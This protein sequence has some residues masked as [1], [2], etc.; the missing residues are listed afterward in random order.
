MTS[1]KVL[2]VELCSGAGGMA[3]GFRRA[4]VTFDVVIDKD[5]NAVA[6]YER[7]LGHCPVQMDVR[8]VLRLA[9]LGAFRPQVRLLVADPPCTPWSLAGKRKG[10]EDER[11]VLAETCELVEILRPQ[12]FLIANIPGLEAAPNVAAVQKTIGRLAEHG[13]CVRDAA[14]LDAAD[15][16]VP[17]HRVRPFWFGHLSGPCLR[18]PAPT[19]RDPG[20]P[21]LAFDGRKP[22]VTC[23]QALGHLPA[24]DLGRVVRGRNGG[25]PR[26]G[27]WNRPSCLDSQ[28]RTIRTARMYGTDQPQSAREIDADA[29]APAVQGALE[30]RNARATWPASVRD[31]FDRPATTV[32]AGTP[33]LW[34]P[35]SGAPNRR[36]WPWDAPSTTVLRDERLENPG[37]HAPSEKTTGGYVRLSE[38]AAAI[39]QGF[40]ENW[41]FAGST[42]S[43]RW[44]QIG[45]ATPP[46]LAE[47]V[48]RQI[49]AWLAARE[50]EAEF[51]A[52]P[53]AD[54]PAL[55]AELSAVRA[56]LLAVVRAME[57]WG[58]WE[59]GVP[60]AGDGKTGSV[61]RAYD[62]AVKMLGLA[63]R[64]R[65]R[66]H[67][68]QR[69][70]DGTDGRA[71]R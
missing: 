24:E 37:H 5:P 57:T 28:A 3:E 25:V 29:P 47:A 11:D 42:K 41:R 60:E 6:S 64:P 39:L 69:A 26:P 9:R 7:N 48:A 22:W 70:E 15:Y 36:A 62:D 65:S 38:R 19:H 34:P 49:A 68:E 56:I 58:S 66:L 59:D 61:G 40:P 35:G 55:V 12:A 51:V 43:A 45:Q 31:Y 50:T 33:Q 16:G 54:V 21:V 18:W 1:A 23:R 8:D 30:C 2:D 10:L 46:P 32:Y 53:R 13:Y 17:Q 20:L 71:N 14:L 52:H 44:S 4:G 63:R 27:E 67:E